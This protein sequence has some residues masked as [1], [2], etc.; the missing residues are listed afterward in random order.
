MAEMDTKTILKVG[1]Q[2]WTA[3]DTNPKTGRTTTYT[4]VSVEVEDKKGPRKM[5]LRTA[6]EKLLKAVKPGVQV[7]G[8]IFKDREAKYA[9][10]YRIRA[11]GKDNPELAGYSQEHGGS[12]HVTGGASPSPASP[13]APAQARYDLAGLEA[14]MGWAIERSEALL[15]ELEDNARVRHAVALFEAAVRVGAKAQGAGQTSEGQDGA[16]GVMPL[17]LA[18]LQQA[19]LTKQ[20]ECTGLPDKKLI[21]LWQAAGGNDAAFRIAAKTAMDMAGGGEPPMAGDE[22]DSGDPPF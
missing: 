19:N 2:T 5:I 6:S 9:D 3:D 21:E 7:T 1:G 15:A 8:Y 14:L 17:I 12:G 20:Y 13:P 10:T 18:A 16:G 11:N 22:D 4:E